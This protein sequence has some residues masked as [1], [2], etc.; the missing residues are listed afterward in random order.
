MQRLDVRLFGQIRA[1]KFCL[2]RPKQRKR[3]SAT[4]AT[5][6]VTIGRGPLYRLDV[7]FF[8]DKGVWQRRMA[9]DPLRV[10]PK[11]FGLFLRSS[12]GAALA[13]TL[14]P[15][16]VLHD[17]PG[18]LDDLALGPVSGR[19]PD[20]FVALFGGPRRV[21]VGAVAGRSDGGAVERV[22]HAP[23]R[24]GVRGGYRCYRRRWQPARGAV[25]TGDAVR[26]L[27]TGSAPPTGAF[28]R[29]ADI[30]RAFFHDEY[31][32]GLEVGKMRLVLT[33]CCD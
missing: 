18:G 19:E 29:G 12:A 2:R 25:H 13:R 27:S 5:G 17:F 7:P 15:L 8:C 10:V 28:R 21:D 14:A 6:A 30:F 11:V 20:P 1:G 4:L 26:S 22:L 32:R 23:A 33:G 24:R 16:E 3:R 9:E 31:S